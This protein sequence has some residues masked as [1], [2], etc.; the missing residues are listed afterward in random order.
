MMPHTELQKNLANFAKGAESFARTQ[1]ALDPREE[2]VG[3]TCTVVVVFKESGDVIFQVTPKVKKRLLN[4]EA[5]R[6]LIAEMLDV[7]FGSLDN[8]S[9]SYDPEDGIESW[10]IRYARLAR[11]PAYSKDYHVYGFAQFI[12]QALADIKE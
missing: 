2:L 1:F 5:A 3:S 6:A 12:N 4:N 7:Y 9:A 8:L 10:A 11:R